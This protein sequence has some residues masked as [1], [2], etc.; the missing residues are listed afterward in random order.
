MDGNH[1]TVLI[2]EDDPGVARL[3]QRRLE[4]AG[5]TVVCAGTAKEGMQKLTQGG[6]ELGPVDI[7][8]LNLECLGS[9]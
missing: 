9:V 7:P 8:L 3:Q 2:V 1:G 4:R 5:Y 6:V